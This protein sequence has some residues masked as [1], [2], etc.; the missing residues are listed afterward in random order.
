MAS[1]VHAGNHTYTLPPPNPHP[2][3]PLGPGLILYVVRLVVRVHGF[4]RYL[5]AYVEGAAGR[6]AEGL[7]R[8]VRGLW[9]S[10]AAEAE[11]AAADG[12][13]Q[14]A[15]D[16]RVMPMLDTGK[17][18]PADRLGHSETR[19]CQDGWNP[20]PHDMRSQPRRP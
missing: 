19:I 16:G 9:C 3:V 20:W 13:L 15:L 6:A 11:L 2:P 1:D 18:R 10:E 17:P 14:S 8:E 5:R 4:V 12:R 7:G